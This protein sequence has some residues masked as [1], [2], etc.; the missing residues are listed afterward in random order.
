MDQNKNVEIVADN[1][2]SSEADVVVKS[3]PQEPSQD[4]EEE[5]EE[6]RSVLEPEVGLSIKEEVSDS[7]DSLPNGDI[8]LQRL[9]GSGKVYFLLMGQG[10]SIS[11]TTYLLIRI[12]R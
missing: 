12:D 5:E 11:S 6:S 2:D 9:K 1:S 4:E 8:L 3:E 7:E 10:P